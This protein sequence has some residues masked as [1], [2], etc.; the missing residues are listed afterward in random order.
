[1]EFNEHFNEQCDHEIFERKLKVTLLS[2]EGSVHFFNEAAETGGHGPT[3][4]GIR[5]KFTLPT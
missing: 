1:M 4:R 3:S 5:R 2:F